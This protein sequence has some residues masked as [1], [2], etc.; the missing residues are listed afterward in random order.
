[1][2]IAHVA[3][4]TKDL[5]RSADFWRIVFDAAIGSPYHSK[6]NK[7]FI[8]R[9]VTLK[10]G[11]PSIELMTLPML[12][13]NELSVHPLVGWAHIAISIG[14]ESEVDTM[15]KRML[16]QDALVSGPRWTGDGFYEAVIRDPDG[17]LIEITA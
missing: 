7:G 1:M 5:E 11:G 2:R 16:E 8:S 6:T 10:D 17:N 13:K 9:F 12:S 3:L 15:A 4:W 14:S